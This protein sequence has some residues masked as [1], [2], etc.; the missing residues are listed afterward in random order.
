MAEQM[1]AVLVDFEIHQKILSAMQGFSET[2]NDVLHRLLDVPKKTVSEPAHSGPPSSSLNSG[3]AWVS[4][5]II[6]PHGTELTMTFHGK[7]FEGVIDNG[8]WLVDGI[9]HGS[10]SGAA[11]HIAETNGGQRFI[12]GW[13]YWSVKRPGDEDWTVLSL[14]K[15]QLENSGAR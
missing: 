7:V 11:G 6:L 13:R 4:G 9:R 12:N 1:R 3:R 15:Y 2:P 10:P 14:L 5:A 8:R